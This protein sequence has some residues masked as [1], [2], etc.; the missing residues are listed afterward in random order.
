M[1]TLIAIIF[2]KKFAENQHKKLTIILSK[3]KMKTQ[4]IFFKLNLSLT[5]YTMCIIY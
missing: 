5:I 2:M 1:N 3:H 4:K